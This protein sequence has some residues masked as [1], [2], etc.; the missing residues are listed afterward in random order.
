MPASRQNERRPPGGPGAVLARGAAAGLA[1]TAAMTVMMFAARRRGTMRKLPPERITEAMLD[2]LRLRRSERTENVISSVAHLAYGAG[3]GALFA[4]LAG[5]LRRPGT[6]VLAGPAY[7]LAL[8]AASYVGWVP[9]LGI[10]PPPHRDGRRRPTA[11]VLAHVTYGA[12][13][14]WLLRG[15]QLAR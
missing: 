7:G 10:M 14:G 13:L 4:V 3:A 12:V 6:R 2:A 1:A 9:A 8:W 5:S 15:R 11:M